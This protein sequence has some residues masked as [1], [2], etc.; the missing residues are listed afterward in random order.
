MAIGTLRRASIGTCTGAALSRWNVWSF[1]TFIRIQTHWIWIEPRYLHA[2]KMQMSRNVVVTN[3]IASN[4][5]FFEKKT[6]RKGQRTNIQWIYLIYLKIPMYTEFHPMLWT[7]VTS[8]AIYLATWRQLRWMQYIS[9]LFDFHSFPSSF[10]L[11]IYSTISRWCDNISDIS[12]VIL[13]LALY[14]LP[15]QCLTILAMIKIMPNIS[16]EW[17]FSAKITTLISKNIAKIAL[18]EVIKHF[19]FQC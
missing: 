11:S 18:L 1:S 12:F 7:D 6:N 5:F 8:F 9:M 3:C 16:L 13:W 15:H 17:I 2:L 10:F 4:Q 19:L 14:T